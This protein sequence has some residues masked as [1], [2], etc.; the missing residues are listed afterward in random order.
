[1]DAQVLGN[2]HI[3]VAENGANRVTERDRN[4]NVK[5]EYVIQGG[6]PICCQRLPN[7]NTFIA[8]YNQLIE[9]RP[10]KTE[11]YRYVPGPQFYIFGARK[12]RTGT[13]ACV[14]AQGVLLEVDPVHNKTVRSVTMGPRIGG[15]A[16]I[17]P[18]PNGNFLVATMNNNMIR[19][20]DGKG[21][22]V[23]SV[24]SPIPGVFRATRLPNGN[25]LVV[26]MSTRE[27]AELDRTGAVRWRHT[28]QGRPW[29]VHYR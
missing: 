28:C 22:T 16:G 1:M 8:M 26:S 25:H 15:W 10:D 2:G 19:E 24:T 7:G 12:T 4:G 14:T 3:L 18:L 11:V 6:N 5:W 20:V 27:V 17:E 13:V 29:N 21:T 23:W 9:V